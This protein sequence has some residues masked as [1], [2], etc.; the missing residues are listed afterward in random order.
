MKEAIIDAFN[1]YLKINGFRKVEKHIS[2]KTNED[3]ETI[4]GSEIS[5]VP[6]ITAVNNGVNYYYKYL[7]GKHDASDL[8]LSFKKFLNNKNQK[9]ELK[10]LVPLQQ[11]DGVLQVL[12]AHQ[13]EGIGII[14]V[15][16]R[17][18]AVQ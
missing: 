14:R 6:D 12:N 16:P 9:Q 15:S 4:V 5:F 8:I 10:L 7:E 17:K 3:T 1:N 2:D 11:S 18:T 13:L